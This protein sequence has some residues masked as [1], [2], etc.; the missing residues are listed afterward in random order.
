MSKTIKQLAEE[1]GISKQALQKR[2]AREPLHTSIQPYISTE[3]NTK[4][5]ATEGET[6][7]KAAYNKQDANK[8]SIDNSQVH[9]DKNIDKSVSIDKYIAL[10]ERQNKTLTAQLDKKDKQLDAK[11]RQ[12]AEKDRQIADLTAAIANATAATNGAQALHAADKQELT[13]QDKPID[14]QTAPAPSAPKQTAQE[15]PQAS[16]G[17]NNGS[18]QQPEKPTKKGIFANLF[19]RKG[20]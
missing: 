9:T 12:I 18:S 2:I 5:I 3:N 16:P 17:Q 6:L 7:I 11:D 15:Q 4:Y 19:S 14:I 1:L 10:L 13:Q 20:R 8:K